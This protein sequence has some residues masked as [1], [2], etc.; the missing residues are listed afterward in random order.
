MD[1]FGKALT[2]FYRKGHSKKLWLHN[3]YGKPEDMPVDIFFR[4]PAELSE[5]ELA[6]LAVCRGKVLDIG[7]GAGAHSLVLQSEGFDVTALEISPAAAEI[8]RDRGV[9]KVI[10]GDIRAY[11]AETYDTLLMLMNGIGLCADVRGLQVLLPQLKSL[12]KEKGQILLDSSDIA[13]LYRPGKFPD[14]YYYGEI[15]YQYEYQGDK[16]EWFKWL[17]I[18]FER[19]SELAASFGFACELLFEDDMDQYLARLSLS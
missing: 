9:R 6:A 4:S 3:S 12:L 14:D 5:L 17:Y 7:A 15:S 8:M 16:G 1:V 11:S 13:Y 2:D 19:L 18:D 10:H